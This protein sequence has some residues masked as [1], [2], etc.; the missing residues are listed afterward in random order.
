MNTWQ[1]SIGAIVGVLLMLPGSVAAAAEE[2]IDEFVIAYASEHMADSR[3]PGMVFV[4][5]DADGRTT[6]SFG[7]A[8]VEANRRMTSTT[9]LRVGSISKPVT[10]ATALELAAAGVLDLDVP[11]D[12][13]LEVDLSDEYGEASTLRELLQHRGGYSDGIVGSHHTDPTEAVGLDEWISDPPARSIVNGVVAS[14]SSIGYT[15]AG[16]AIEG[17]TADAF[18]DVAERVVFDPLGM[19]GATFVQPPP[20][21]VAIGYEWTDDVRTAFPVDATD[22]VPGAGLTASA[23]DIAAFMTALVRNDSPLDD[24]TVDALLTPA[25]PAPEMRAFTTGL[26]EWRYGERTVLYHEGNGMGTT[27][28]MMILPDEGVGIFTA[29]NA[30]AMTGIG[31]PSIQSRFVRDL[32]QQ[33]IERFY[34]AQMSTVD[35]P[36]QAGRGVPTEAV[37]GT[38]VPTRVDTASPLRLEALVSQVD[39][40]TTPAGIAFGGRP[41]VERGDGFYRSESR[42]LRFYE[43]PDGLTYATMGGTGSF[44]QAAWWETTAANLVVL[45][46][47]LVAMFVGLGLGARRATGRVRILMVGTTA[48]ALAFVGLL[49]YG[50]LNV[51]VMEVF[52]GLPPMIRLAQAA[53]LGLGA[54]AILGPIVLLARRD[55]PAAR[56]LG[57]ALTV[58]IA[59]LVL[60]GWA[61]AWTILPI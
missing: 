46:G 2:P 17:A 53:A 40:S 31:D 7:F 44:R 26:T 3:V 37:T 16:A 52:T 33:L 54:A 10:A 5:V 48:L 56:V 30:A 20:A 1:R 18:A 45:G 42:D 14:Y 61:L 27:N 49:G 47:S 21:D 57:S 6:H 22:L 36:D 8:D 38:Y 34:P 59:G 50:L 15:V 55:V 39:V 28:R 41:Y 25:G 23:E 60:T 29:V 11:V 12:G 43:G 19:Q 58:S 13:Y 24:H 32:H 35:A 51:E 4:I 9:P